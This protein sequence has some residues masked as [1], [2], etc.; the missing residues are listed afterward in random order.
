LSY[1]QACIAGP[2][3]NKSRPHPN[4]LLFLKSILI[5]AYLPIRARV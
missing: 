1:F 2:S 4:T 5:L 3:L